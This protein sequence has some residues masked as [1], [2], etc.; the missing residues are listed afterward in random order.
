MNKSRSLQW[1]L[2]AVTAFMV[3]AS[4]LAISCFISRSAIFYM[5]EIKD[6][7]TSIF[8]KESFSERS[9]DVIEVYIDPQSML[10]E[11]IKNTQAEF[12]TKSLLITLIITLLSCSMM[13]FIM[14]YVLHPLQKLSKQIEDIQARNL[15]RLV[16]SDSSS[17][18]IVRLTNSFNEM[19]KRLN[20]TF[21]AQRQ[22]S[23]NA[24]HELRTPL[25]VIRTRLEVFEKKRSPV[26]SDYQE[27]VNMVR[28]QTDRL[29]HVIDILLEMTELQSAKK[30]DRILLAEMTEEVVCDLTAVGD[31]KGVRI[32]QKPGDAQITGN[33]TLIYRAIY[34]LI[35]NA[36]K[37]NH[38][39][40]EV[41]IEITESGEFAKV[42]VSDTGT[43]IDRSDW[44][45][46]FDPFFRAD[47]S[48]S[49][50][51]GGAGLGLALV[52]EISHQHGGDVRVVRSSEHG[53]QIELTLRA[54]PPAITATAGV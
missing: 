20:N 10:S 53:T 17:I 51:M 7:A 37:Y 5:G 6:S 40:G 4:C 1:R 11:M 25:A 29:S 49:R 45:Q 27:T 33:D 3:I 15:Q 38:P 35:E 42:I 30:S 2:T 9:S 39:G 44:E 54:A 13:Y 12:W 36:I 18:E 50:D 14:G 22:F 19:L 47:K 46:I 31:K 21:S 41:S 16:I 32:I 26:L 24:A 8:P 52:K 43:G 48:R 34:N 28:T 23:A